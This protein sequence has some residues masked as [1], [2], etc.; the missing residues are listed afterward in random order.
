VKFGANY[1]WTGTGRLGNE[2]AMKTFAIYN[3]APTHAPVSIA[4]V[5]QGIF[6]GS[7]FPAARL[8]HAFVTEA[9]PDHAPG[10]QIRG[11]RIVEFDIDASNKLVSGPTTLVEYRGAGRGTTIGLTA[12]PDGL[13]FTD[14]YK[15]LDAGAATDPGASVWRV[16]WVG[17]GG[18][19]LAVASADRQG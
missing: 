9:G 8:D 6:G 16:R 17:T 12:G 14:L 10:P 18:T 2:A 3:W 1:G 5:Q 7:G 13:Y 19:A 4:F 11:K 15:D